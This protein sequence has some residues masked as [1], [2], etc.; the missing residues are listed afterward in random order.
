MVSLISINIAVSYVNDNLHK[1]RL[2]VSWQQDYLAKM[3]EGPTL[4]SADLSLVQWSTMLGKT[5]SPEAHSLK[6]LEMI[7]QFPTSWKRSYKLC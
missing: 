5:N 2:R 3:K 7:P 6:W 4:H 1:Q